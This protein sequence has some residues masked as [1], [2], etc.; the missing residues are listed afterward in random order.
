MKK[1]KITTEYIREKIKEGR[2][3]ARIVE[4][5]MR[6]NSK[7]ENEPMDFN[8][9]IL[10]VSLGGDSKMIMRDEVRERGGKNRTVLMIWEN[11]NENK[12]LVIDLTDASEEDALTEINSICYEAFSEG[13][14][15]TIKCLGE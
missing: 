11:I 10:K 3:R 7:F 1:Y 5:V 15:V 4:K 9:S 12:C 14:N 2:E 6:A 13:N 8:F